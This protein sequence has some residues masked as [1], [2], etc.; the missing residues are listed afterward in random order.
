MKT[1]WVLMCV[2]GVS[3]CVADV[4]TE[5]VDLPA[6]EEQQIGQFSPYLFAFYT[7]VQDEPGPGR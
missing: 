3:G 5:A 4:E 6:V 2:V 1:L 7:T